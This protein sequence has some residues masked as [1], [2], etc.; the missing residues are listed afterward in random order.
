MKKMIHNLRKQ[1]EHAR[2]HLLHLLTIIGAIIL[3]ILWGYSLSRT[4]SS[5]DTK[6]KIQ[7]DLKPFSML[8]DSITQ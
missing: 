8:K 3:I 2:R 5:P 4:W 7:Q 6:V 1:P